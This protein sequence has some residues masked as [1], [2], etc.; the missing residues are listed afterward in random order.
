MVQRM[1]LPHMAPVQDNEGNLHGFYPD[2]Y[3]DNAYENP[4]IENEP[5]EVE[6]E[7]DVDDPPIDLEGDLAS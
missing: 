7:V 2:Y 5:E 6:I 1:M 3:A 4:V